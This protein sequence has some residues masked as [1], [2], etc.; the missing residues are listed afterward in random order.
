[1]MYGRCVPG[2]D[3]ILIDT[4]VWIDLL[5]GLV[6]ALTSRMLKILSEESVCMALLILQALLRDVRSAG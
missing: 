6:T 1:M 2:W 3:A 4:P 5:R